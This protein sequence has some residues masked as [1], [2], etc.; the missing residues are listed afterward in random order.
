MKRKRHT[1]DESIAKLGEADGLPDHKPFNTQHHHPNSRCSQHD[2]IL[3]IGQANLT[4]TV[5]D[6]VAEAA[7][8]QKRA[9]ASPAATVLPPIW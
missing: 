8:N 6:S 2:R 9:S 5:A 3:R 4:K 1:P 7:R